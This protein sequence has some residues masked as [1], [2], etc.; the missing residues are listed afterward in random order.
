MFEAI[1]GDF[2]DADES[3][4]L[5]A[6]G[7]QRFLAT[8]NVDLYQIERQLNV[9]GLIDEQAKYVTLAG[10]LSHATGSLPHVGMRA[11]KA[12]LRFE[13]ESMQELTIDK[14]YISRI[15]EEVSKAH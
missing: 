3:P 15:E 11:E 8:G 4:D 7:D 14:V 6:L 12:G 5:V 13:I 10:L 1:A 2:P 9:T